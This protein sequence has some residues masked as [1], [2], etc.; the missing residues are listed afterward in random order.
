MSFLIGK[1][2]KEFRQEFSEKL[3]KSIY[4]IAKTL[5]TG[6]VDKKGFHSLKVMT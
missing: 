5:P 2:E 3:N 1:R 6:A 4:L